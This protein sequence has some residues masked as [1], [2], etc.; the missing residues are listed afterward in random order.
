MT[1][2]EDGISAQSFPFKLAVAPSR[3]EEPVQGRAYSSW[4]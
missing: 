3:D 1:A 2:G 4:E